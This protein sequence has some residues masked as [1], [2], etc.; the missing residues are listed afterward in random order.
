[1]RYAEAL[2]RALHEEMARDERVCVIGEDVGIYGGVFKVTKGLRERFGDLRVR[3]TPI[4]EQAMTGLAIGAAMVGR[5]PVLEI[6]Y[7]DFLTLCL[8][9]LVNQASIVHYIWAG[10]A[11]LPFV[12]RTQGGAGAGAAAQHSKSLDAL[13]AHVPGLKVVAPATPADASG[14]LVAAI[15]DPNPVVFLEHKLLY[16][17]TGEVPEG[18][19]VVPI[20]QAHVAR[21]GTDITIVASSKMTLDA[22]AAAETLA[23]EGIDAEVVD[24]RTLRPLDRETIARS[25]RKTNRALVVNEGWTTG[26]FGAELSAVIM[27]D[28]FDWLDGPVRRLGTADRPIPYSLPLEQAAVPDAAAITRAARL[29]LAG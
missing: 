15:R 2:N 14:L 19:H 18:D 10:Q 21:E 4:S 27:E 16:N 5:R 25:V 11:S 17:T 7:I 22:L 3:D 29:T 24:L 23:A 26:G 6:M 1:M 12:L 20:G 9:Q 28:A 8:D 13:V